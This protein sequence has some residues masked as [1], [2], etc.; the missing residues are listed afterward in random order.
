VGAVDFLINVA[1]GPV[2]PTREDRSSGLRIFESGRT[3]MA[4]GDMP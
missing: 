1:G 2:A 4:Q 3:K